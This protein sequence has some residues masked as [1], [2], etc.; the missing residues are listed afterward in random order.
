[1]EKH[2]NVVA[3]LQIGLSILGILGGIF[4]FLVLH[5][6]GVLIDNQQAGTILSVIARVLSVFI[7]ICCVPGIIAGAGLFRRKEWAR[8]LA[9]I[10]SVIELINFPL[11][12][13]VGVYSIWA[14]V[15]PEIVKMFKIDGTV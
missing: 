13:A 15:Q 6:T 3:A 10:I 7:F 9:L 1:M 4:L 12:T 14:L 2:I 8:I 5:F 11:G